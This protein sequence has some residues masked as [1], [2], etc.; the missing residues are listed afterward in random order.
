MTPLQHPGHFYLGTYAKLRMR[1][2][3]KVSAK[4]LFGIILKQ[5]IVITLGRKG[6]SGN[7]HFSGDAYKL[8]GHVPDILLLKT[9]EAVL[10]TRPGHILCTKTH[11]H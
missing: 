11:P 1:R 2:M 6:E 8:Q 3:E 7:S 5:P 4:F 9:R 10:H